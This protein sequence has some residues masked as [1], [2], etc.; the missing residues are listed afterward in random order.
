MSFYG[1]KNLFQKLGPTIIVVLG[2][3]ATIFIFSRFFTDSLPVWIVAPLLIA[4]FLVFG[5]LATAFFRGKGSRDQRG[6]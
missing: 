5:F 4:G 6:R 1:L 2:L 3:A